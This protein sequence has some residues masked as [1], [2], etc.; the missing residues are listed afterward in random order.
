MKVHPAKTLELKKHKDKTIGAGMFIKYLDECIDN[1]V[2]FIVSPCVDQELTS[3][4]LEKC[5]DYTG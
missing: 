1:K 3:Y 4:A 2:D 5:L